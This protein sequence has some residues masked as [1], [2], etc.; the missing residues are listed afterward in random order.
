VESDER[1]FHPTPEVK[2]MPR[3]DLFTSIHKA[4]RAMIYET[5]GALQTADFADGQS[6]GRAVETL[7]PALGQMQHHHDLEEEHV[8]PRVRPYEEQMIDD[9]QAQ[10]DHVERLLGAAAASADAVSSGDPATRPGAGIEL[11]RRYN[12]LVAL[13]L[14]HLAHEE[15]TLLPATWKHFDDAQLVAVQAAIISS[16][17]PEDLMQTLHWMF[18]GLN[19][20]ELVGMLSAAGATMPPPALAAIREL[21]AASMEPAAWQVVREQSGL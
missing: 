5:G 16:Q 15:D 18:R 19:R 8:F 17:Q 14:D 7:R 3:F 4:L 1:G 10:H 6:A 9:L 2:A 21:G 11:N 13:F 20:P 12:E